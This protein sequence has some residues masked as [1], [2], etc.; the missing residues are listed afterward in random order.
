M[1]HN[2]DF[3]CLYPGNNTSSNY[4]Y[5][6]N[7]TLHISVADIKLRILF[8]HILSSKV[9][10]EVFEEKSRSCLVNLFMAWPN[11]TVLG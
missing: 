9:T 7:L 11:L 3:E 6:N 10:L 2:V 4:I 1:L 5:H 8:S